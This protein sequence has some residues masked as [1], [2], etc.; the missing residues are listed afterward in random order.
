MATQSGETPLLDLLASMTASSVESTN[1]DPRSLMLVRIAALVAV[2]APAASYMLNLGAAG[3]L[4]V[5][6]DEV[7]GLLAGVA[8]I[9]GTTRIVS[10]VGKLVRALDL[11]L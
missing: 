6:A 4:G 10:A 3:E 1:L 8:P 5:T 2:D 9:V 7:E 11:K